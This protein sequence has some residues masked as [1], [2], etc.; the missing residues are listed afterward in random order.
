MPR[1][2]PTLPLG[3]CWVV[4]EKLGVRPVEP[5]IKSEKSVGPGMNS[6]IT[7]M[8]PF[9]SAGEKPLTDGLKAWGLFLL[10]GVLLESPVNPGVKMFLGGEVVFDKG[11]RGAGRFSATRG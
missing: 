3:Y 4:S 7:G 6:D 8:L 10:F 9:E 11:E 2:D 5:V 1:G